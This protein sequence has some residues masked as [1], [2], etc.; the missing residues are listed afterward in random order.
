VRP[1]PPLRH[2]RSPREIF[3]RSPCRIYCFADT[4]ALC[5]ALLGAGARVI[6][7]R[8]K[9]LDDDRF[10]KLA[11]QMLARTRRHEN[12]LLIINDRVDIALETGAD[13][14]HVGQQDEDCA[15]VIRRLPPEMIVGVSARYP[16]LAAD[17]ERKG[18]A[19]IGAGSVAAT[20][21]KPDADV[22]GLAGVRAVVTATAIPVVAIGGITKQNIRQVADTGVRYCAVISGINDAPNPAA[23]FRQLTASLAPFPPGQQAEPG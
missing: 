21:T 11:R 23:V 8:H 6:Q 3:L 10:R 17:A 9:S 16:G 4:V 2:N 12:A 5:E 19:Y 20:S 15:Q 1:Y 18:A 13:G 7:L 22:I 14:V